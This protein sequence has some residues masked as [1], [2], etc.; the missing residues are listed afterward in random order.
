MNQMKFFTLYIILFVSAIFAQNLSISPDTQSIDVNQNAEIRLTAGGFTSLRAYSVTVKYNPIA[1]RCI[2]VTK[3]GFLSANYS[4]FFYYSLDTIAGT[5]SIDEAILGSGFVF[6]AGDIAEIKFSGIQNGISLLNITHKDFRDS[7]NVNIPVA[8]SDGKINIGRASAAFEK[9]TEEDA[10]CFIKN[11]PNPF[12][13]ATNI[14]FNLKK[15]EKVNITIYNTAGEV[16][17]VL[18]NGFL[19]KGLHFVNWNG[20]NYSSGLYIAVLTA[21][22]ITLSSKMLLIK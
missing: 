8:S 4:T 10:L 13:P 15:D 9:I 12:N 7:N 5:M 21:G 17:E 1:A 14:E 16:V 19:Q 11:Y 6:G 20:K 18:M 2:G 22:K 3:S